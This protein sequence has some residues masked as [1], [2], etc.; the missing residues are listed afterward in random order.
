MGLL[1]FGSL[2]PLIVFFLLTAPSLS[3]GFTYN[4]KSVHTVFGTECGDYFNWQSIGM[5][6]SHMKAKQVRPPRSF[7]KNFQKSLHF[8]K[9]FKTTGKFADSNPVPS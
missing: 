1:P 4:G 9:F 6:Y 3:V 8:L 7:L 5:I 2:R